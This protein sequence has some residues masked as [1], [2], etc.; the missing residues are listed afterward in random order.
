M[1]PLRW[2]LLGGVGALVVVCTLGVVAVGLPQ[3]S[4]FLARQ[5]PHACELAARDSPFGEV[6]NCILLSRRTPPLS[7]PGHVF[8]L[9]E[10]GTGP[11]VLRLDY[12]GTDERDFKVSAVEVPT[13]E[14]PGISHD[15]GERIKTGIDQRG[16]LKTSPW[17]INP[18]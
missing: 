13:W 4:S 6:T 15:T 10:T 18:F 2:W 14:S 1:N 16:G 8:L 7:G 5:A 11:T 12:T 3:R 9:L 17:A